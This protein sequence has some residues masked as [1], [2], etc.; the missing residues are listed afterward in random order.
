M[1]GIVA[2]VLSAIGLSQIYK[3]QE[4]GKV[5]A[6]LGIILG[7]INIIYAVCILIFLM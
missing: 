2:V 1:V 3:A 4:K 5:L 7:A 6:I